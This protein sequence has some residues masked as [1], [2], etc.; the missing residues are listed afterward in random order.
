MRLTVDAI[1]GCLLLGGSARQRL[2]GGFGQHLP[3]GPFSV[4]EIGVEI[5]HARA[6]VFGG[7][8]LPI[9]IRDFLQ[10]HAGL[11]RFLFE[12]LPADVGGLLAL[13]EMNPLANLAARARGVNKR[14][15][16]AR[17]RVALLRDDFDHVAIGER[18]TQRNHLA[19]HFRAG[20]LVAD[21]GVDRVG[22]I[23]R[24][25]A[26]RKDHHASFRREGVNLLGIEVHAQSREKFARLL[27]LLHPLDQMAHP[28]DALIVGRR[29]HVVTVFIF[30][31][32][33]DA[34]LGD[35]MHILRSNLHFERLAGMNHG[36]V[37]R[38][39]EVRARHGDVVLESPGHG[40]P[41]L[42]DHAE[43]GVAILHRVGDHAHGQQ[44]VD[45][46][47]IALLLLNFQMH[48]IEPLDARLHFGGNAALDHFLANRVLHF[49]QEFVE[50][51]CLLATFFCSSRNASVSR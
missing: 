30:P 1:F 16:V 24:R 45:L 39:V 20:A 49:S 42:M 38:L 17:G 28:D 13:V 36:R 22:E 26:A 12:Q 2:P 46:I 7:D 14:E 23:N 47:E 33:G 41:D 32:R 48:R 4:A 21:F 15:P 11:P 25:G 34:L 3:R 44:V 50:V 18:V 51:F 9:V 19:I 6:A 27:H 40:P 31:V 10:A 35:A 37:Q 5:V 43:R 29:R 8:A